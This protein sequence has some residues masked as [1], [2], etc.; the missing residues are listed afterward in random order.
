MIMIIIKNK[1]L[2]PK[3]FKAMAVFPFIFWRNEYEINDITINHEKI[4]FQQQKELFIVF[5]YILY[6]IFYLIY[7][8]KKNPFEK[9]AYSN[10]EKEYYL[11]SR[12]MFNFIKY[13]P[14]QQQ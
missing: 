6:L 4:H 5:F 14:W 2:P 11:K 10:D 8:Y 12:K 9:E 13:M 7:G 3:G 1:I